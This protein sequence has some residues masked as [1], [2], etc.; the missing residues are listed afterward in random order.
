MYQEAALDGATVPPDNAEDEVGYHY[1]CFVKSRKTGRIHE[2]DGDIK[3]PVDSGVRVPEDQDLLGFV[4]R[5][6]VRDWI[7]RE[8]ER[9]EQFEFS[10]M[11]L[12]EI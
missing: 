11:A 5:A 1:V 9:G 10:L 8:C 6:F 12:S 7:R 4:G 2:L 3:G